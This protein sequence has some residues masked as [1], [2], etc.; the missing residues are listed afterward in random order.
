MELDSTVYCQTK[1]EWR[2]WLERN[3]S[4]AKEV[5]FIHYKKHTGR[6]TVSYKDAVE[7][8]LCFGWIDAQMKSIDEQKFANR[9]APR[10][11]KSRW[12]KTNKEIAERL[13]G[14]G[15]MTPAGLA[16]IEQAK[17]SGAW[18]NAY[19][20]NQSDEEIPADFQQA[21]SANK[22]A[23]DNFNRLRTSNRNAYI[24]WIGDAKTAPTREK[25]IAEL[26]MRLALNKKL[27]EPL[28]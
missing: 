22:E 7:E 12:S 24:H 21:L 1:Q 5:W 14:E 8:A 2:D 19:V 3:H 15:K 11:A 20:T 10:K 26:V 4:K 23:L 25:R 6:P 13:I 18:D 9:F 17:K 28:E 16:A 27:G